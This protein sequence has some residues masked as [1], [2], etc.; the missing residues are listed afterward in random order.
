MT[1]SS[2]RRSQTVVLPRIMVG[3]EEVEGLPGE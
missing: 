3:L 2:A 1:P